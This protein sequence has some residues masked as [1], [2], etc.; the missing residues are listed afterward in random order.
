MGIIFYEKPFSRITLT[1]KGTN[2]DLEKFDE[3][4]A[5]KKVKA[6]RKECS[7]KN[8][9]KVI[10]KSEMVTDEEESTS[11]G[12]ES[13]ALS[14][15]AGDFGERRI[16]SWAEFEERF[17]KDD[18]LK[19][20]IQNI[21]A[22][23][24]SALLY[25]LLAPFHF[26]D[27]GYID[28]YAVVAN[29]DNFDFIHP[30]ENFS[31]PGETKY[32]TFFV[33]NKA[34]YQF[35]KAY[36]SPNKQNDILLKGKRI[37]DYLYKPFEFY[38][39]LPVNKECVQLF[40]EK[41]MLRETK[42]DFEQGA[43]Y[44]LRIF[45]D[46]F[47][48]EVSDEKDNAQDFMKCHLVYSASPEID[49]Y[50]FISVNN[51]FDLT[52]AEIDKSKKIF[53]SVLTEACKNSG[54]SFADNN[55]INQLMTIVNDTTSL[56]VCSVGFA[57]CI[58]GTTKNGH[59]YYFDIG[60]PLPG[61][62]EKMTFTEI[63]KRNNVIATLIDGKNYVPDFIILSHWHYDHLSGAIKLSKDK[64]DKTEWLAPKDEKFSHKNLYRACT[65][66]LEAYLIKNGLIQ[67]VDKNAYINNTIYNTNDIGIFWGTGTNDINTNGLMLKIKNVLLPADTV[68]R[69]WPK[70]F[71]QRSLGPN[72]FDYLVVPHHGSSYQVRNNNRY[73]DIDDFIK[74]HLNKGAEMIISVGGNKYN[75]VPTD[76][77]NK[78]PAKTKVS[79]LIITKELKD[80]KYEIKIK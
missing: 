29:N 60:L 12:D 47:R 8:K 75:N 45:K 6:H 73:N 71:T 76:H 14:E 54:P 46:P 64:L 5:R 72:Y 37:I 2:L 80:F 34:M 19:E 59:H 69:F 57:N 77:Y 3:Y 53:Q 28:L 10:S 48:T 63:D 66:L 24:R 39:I 42:I 36:F 25:K 31:Y 49:L 78:L 16:T 52:R 56:K 32:I 13:T 50:A 21:K 70:E 38:G 4:E 65:T 55:K 58:L 11:A 44:I 35:T 74:N 26:N 1:A 7:A 68:Y 22:L 15:L 51:L 43:T 62:C 9:N 61:N 33:F 18:R 30:D 27:E 23:D 67:Y 40:E 20:E 41:N 17:Q 79:R